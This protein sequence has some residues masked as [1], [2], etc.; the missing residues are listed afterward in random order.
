MSEQ[1]EILYCEEGDN[2]YC[3]YDKSPISIGNKY[4]IQSDGAVLSWDSWVL[5]QSSDNDDGYDSTS[6]VGY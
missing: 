3:Q 2:L 5:I 6:D 1:I 4:V